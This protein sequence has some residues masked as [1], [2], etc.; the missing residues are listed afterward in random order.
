MF[1]EVS[2][3][4]K[5]KGIAFTSEEEEKICK[6]AEGDVLA[7]LNMVKTC[8]DLVIKLANW[9]S[10]EN[11]IEFTKMIQVGVMAIIRAAETFDLSKQTNFIDYASQMIVKEMVKTSKVYST[12]IVCPN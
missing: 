9:Y 3:T 10:L 8:M 11:G 7:K 12:D 2:A 1:A 5:Y 6:I 4:C